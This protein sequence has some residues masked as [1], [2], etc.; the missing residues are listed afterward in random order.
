MEKHAEEAIR[1]KLS[2]DTA[3][4]GHCSGP[5]RHY[6]L[7]RPDIACFACGGGYISRIVMYGMG[8]DAAAL[9]QFIESISGGAIDVR[10]EDI[11][12]ATRHPWEMGLEGRSTGEKV[13][14][15]AYWNQ[16]YRRGKSDDA[17]R[18]ALFRCTACGSPFTQRF[19]TASP[20][21]G[22]CT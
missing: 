1:L 8:A 9:R 21:C 2:S 5:A 16:N 18:I 20:R 15:E 12:I 13:M 11:R 7:R 19:D 6:F 4:Y 17:S 14:T 10:D 3:C 22:A